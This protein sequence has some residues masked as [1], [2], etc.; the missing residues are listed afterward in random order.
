[1]FLAIKSYETF[2]EN[3]GRPEAEGAITD[4]YPTVRYC[5]IY[6]FLLKIILGL[7]ISYKI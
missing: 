6:E 1:M 4:F 5:A 3:R 7:V 2:Y